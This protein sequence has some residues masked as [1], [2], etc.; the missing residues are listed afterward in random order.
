[1]IA[2]HVDRRAGERAAQRHKN[3]QGI[4]RRRPLVH[5]EIR[6]EGDAAQGP[7]QHDVHVPKSERGR[8]HAAERETA[9]RG[10]WWKE[11]EEEGRDPVKSGSSG[12]PH[13]KTRDGDI[14]GASGELFAHF[15]RRSVFER[16][17]AD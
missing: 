8:P 2:D 14:F 13:R 4:V 16:G 12:P 17:K 7:R 1:M 15:F 11:R 10:E 6:A 5:R 9:R 3:D